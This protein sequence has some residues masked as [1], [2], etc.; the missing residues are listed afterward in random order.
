[1]KKLKLIF[2]ILSRKQKTKFL[3]MSL[4]SFVL[5]ILELVGLGFVFPVVSIIINY[6]EFVEFVSKYESLKFILNYDQA[7]VLKGSLAIMVLFFLFKNIITVA[8]TYI[9]Q[10]I[11]YSLIADLSSTLYNG[12]T[13]QSTGFIIEKNSAYIIRNIIDYPAAFVTYVLQGIYNILFELL[14]VIGTMTIFFNVNLYVGFLIFFSITLFIIFFYYKNRQRLMGLGKSMNIQYAERLKTTREAIEGYKEISLHDKKDFFERIFLKHTYRI[15]G[16][17]SILVLKEIIPKHLL[18]FLSILFISLAIL[19]F[20]N[21]GL[22]MNSVIPA[23]SIITAGLIRL[24]PSISKIHSSLLR[25]KSNDPV[26]YELYNEIR[27]ILK[28]NENKNKLLNFKNKIEIENIKFEYAEN[29]LILD[30]LN[31]NIKKNSIFGLKGKSGSGKTTCLNII[32]GFLNPKNG[33]VKV[34]DN[35]VRDNVYNWQKLIGYIPQKVFL[36]DDTL[37]NNIAFGISESEINYE[38][39]NSAIKYSQ[40]DEVIESSK[41]GLETPVGE[42]GNKLSS[43]QIQRIGLARALYKK[44]QI[45]ILDEATSALDKETENKILEDIT[46]LKNIYTVIMVSH[47][48]KVLSICDKIYDLDKK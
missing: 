47:S 25:V 14:F 3:I 24:V 11:Y 21:S 16:I 13:R 29:K 35:D 15:A 28:V 45:L 5:I 10:I 18:E 40:L 2:D 43:G 27:K 33:T 46:K 1:M 44:P 39:L 12:Y 42:I 9:K 48:E 23:I 19:F 30:N 8:V 37:K 36:T 22:S 17:S 4:F 31:F 26:T 32:I 38:N 34:D 7:Q 20:V 6:S 41:L